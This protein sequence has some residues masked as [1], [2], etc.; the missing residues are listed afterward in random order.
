MVRKTVHEPAAVPGLPELWGS[1][2][3]LGTGTQIALL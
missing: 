3:F 2:P 1:G